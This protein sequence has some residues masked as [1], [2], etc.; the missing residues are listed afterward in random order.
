[1]SG[2]RKRDWLVSVPGIVILPL[3][4]EDL[5]LMPAPACLQPLETT[6]VKGARHRTTA[7][8]VTRRER[9]VA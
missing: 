5:P 1:M 6:Q 8:R 9:R 3:Q 2:V 7:C 4:A